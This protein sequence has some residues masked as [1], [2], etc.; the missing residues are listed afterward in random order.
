M[1]LY[2]NAAAFLYHRHKYP[3]ELASPTHYLNNNLDINEFILHPSLFCTSMKY[4]IFPQTFAQTPLLTHCSTM[5]HTN[6]LL[7]WYHCC[8]KYDMAYTADRWKLIWRDVDLHPLRGESESISLSFIKMQ[9]KKKLFKNVHSILCLYMKILP[10]FFNR[11]FLG[12]FVPLWEEWM[13]LKPAQSTGSFC[14]R[15]PR[16]RTWEEP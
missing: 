3:P 4:E 12:V 6:I 13:C 8:Q 10:G 9:K 7:C 2:P 15:C 16:V 5:C 1:G 14:S 11:V